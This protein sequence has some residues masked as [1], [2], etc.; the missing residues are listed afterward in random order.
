MYCP[1]LAPRAADVTR[2]LALIRPPLLALPR[3]AGIFELPP[4]G[5]AYVAGSARAAGHEITVVD[6]VGETPTRRRLVEA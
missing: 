3:Q 6:A 1:C 5:L 4:R 2:K